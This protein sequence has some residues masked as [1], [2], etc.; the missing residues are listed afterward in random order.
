MAPLKVGA[1][2]ITSRKI[3]SSARLPQKLAV[4][5]KNPMH[6]EGVVDVDAIPSPVIE[7]VS[8]IVVEEKEE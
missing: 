8:P 3:L 6:M 2:S 4:E 1:P 5:A 7:L